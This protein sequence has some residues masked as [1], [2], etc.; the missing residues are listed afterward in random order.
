VDDGGDGLVEQTAEPSDSLGQRRKPGGSAQRARVVAAR[1]G[2]WGKFGTTTS[3]REKKAKN[4]GGK[5]KRDQAVS[6]SLYVH[7]LPSHRRT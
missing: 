5:K 3:V 4:D 6:K 1:N 7:L 2:R